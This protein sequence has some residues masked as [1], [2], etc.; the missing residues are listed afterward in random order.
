MRKIDREFKNYEHLL[1][2]KVD[3]NGILF[4]TLSGFPTYLEFDIRISEM[5]KRY[6][7][8]TIC[9]TTRKSDRPIVRYCFEH[10]IP[11]ETINLYSVSKESY[12]VQKLP[13]KVI[14]VLAIIEKPTKMTE[15]ILRYYKNFTVIQLARI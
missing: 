15:R 10:N 7:F 11:L 6:T 5:L 8:G 2:H 14:G 12:L 9:T 13:K 3:K 1:R 4:V